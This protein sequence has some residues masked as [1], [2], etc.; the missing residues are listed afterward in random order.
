VE[1]LLASAVLNGTVAPVLIWFILSASNDGRVVGRH[2]N[3]RL[4]NL[5]GYSTFAIMSLAVI[6]MAL[7]ALA[8][9]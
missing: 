4:S 3:G 7:H 1:A 5:L 8:L 6:V 2:R 9:P